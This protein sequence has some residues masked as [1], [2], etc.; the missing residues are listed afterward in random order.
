MTLSKVTTYFLSSNIFVSICVVA[1]CKSSAILLGVNVNHILPFVFFSTL[2]SY[3]LLRLIRFAYFDNKPQSLNTYIGNWPILAG[4]LCLAIYFSFDISYQSIVL[5]LPAI[6]LTLLYSV[7]IPYRKFSI[8]LREVPSLKVFLIAF[9]WSVVTV[10]L[11]ACEHSILLSWEVTVLFL[12][13]F[14]FIVAI[15]IPFD[16]RDLK[17][18]APSIKTIP[19]RFGVEKAK[20]ISLYFLAVFEVLT[21]IHFFFFDFHYTL[22]LALLLCSLCTGLLIFKSNEARPAFYYSLWLEGASLL[23]LALLFYIPMAFGILVP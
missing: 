1:L 10:G 4:S 6:I 19:Q 5:L 23:M 8:S 20:M 16:I 9:I 3:N 14:F 18:D 22:L 2:F 17:M 13:R 21:I 11:V 7:K 12:S 15:T